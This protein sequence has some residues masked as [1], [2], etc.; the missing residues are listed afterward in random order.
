L[1]AFFSSAEAAFLS[2]RK[3][4]VRSMAENKIEGADRVAQMIEEPER[5]LPTILLVNNLVNTAFTALFTVILISMTGEGKGVILATIVSTILLLIFGETLPKTVGIRYPEKLFF[6]SSRVITFIEK[7]LFPLTIVLQG[8]NKILA[9]RLGADPRAYF[10][11]EEVKT[12]ISI[13]RESGS[14]EEQEA[15][16]LENVFRFGDRQLKEIMTTRTELVLIESDTNLHQFFKVYQNYSHSRFPV[17]KENP[18]NILGILLVKDVM[19]DIANGNISAS[20]IVTKLLRPVNFVPE[21]KTVSTLFREMQQVGNQIAIAVDEFGGISGIVTL[22]QLT[23]E[24]VGPV[25]EDGELPEVEYEEIDDNTFSID[26]GMQIE[27]ANEEL[28][29]SLPPGDYETVAG[30][31]LENL[32]KIPKEGDHC[33]YNDTRLVVT[34]I[35]GMKIEKILITKTPYVNNK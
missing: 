9:T 6:F 7:L 33:M 21:T 5:V 4:R 25:G 19:G 22:K 20:D 17:Y 24:I 32:G 35:T 3:V 27:E 12:A 28:N 34:Q 18:E 26:G 10:S 14:V 31:I 1:S 2:V 30:F 8:I 29:L 13:G 15:Q 23:E 11:E 16:M